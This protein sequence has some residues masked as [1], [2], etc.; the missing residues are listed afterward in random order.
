MREIKS[1]IDIADAYDVYFFDMFGVIWDGYGFYPGVIDV[2]HQLKARGKKIV[3]LSN[4]TVLSNQMIQKVTQKGLNKNVHFDDFITS[5]ELFFEKIQAGFL[6]Q[7][8]G[9]DD[10]KFYIIGAQNLTL[11]ADVS[12][13]QTVDINEADFVYISSLDTPQGYAFTLDKFIPEM[14]QA[15]GLKKKAICANPDITVIRDNVPHFVNGAAAQWYEK[16]GG[17]V[18]Y[19]G[20][21]YPEVYTYALGR[22]GADCQKAVMIGDSLQTDILGAN[23]VGMPSVLITHTGVAGEA[24]KEASLDELCQVHGACPDFILTQVK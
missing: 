11:F 10:F 22:A 6:A 4:A 13:H 14:T 15:L 21:P 3:M 8:A 2:F 18:L 9:R 19:I 16:N 20:K 5:G 1:L 12:A 7:Y 17:Q 24:L 23:R